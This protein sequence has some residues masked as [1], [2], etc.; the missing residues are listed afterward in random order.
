MTSHRGTKAL[1]SLAFG[2]CSLFAVSAR[3]AGGAGGSGVFSNGGNG[4]DIGQAGSASSAG[5]PAGGSAG[6]A[7]G[8]AG[9]PGDGNGLGNAGG[10]GGADGTIAAPTG[11]AGG[12]GGSLSP[13]FHIGGSIGGGGG[14]AGGNGIYGLTIDFSNPGTVQ[15]GAGGA[16]G[17]GHIGNGNGDGANGGG[18]GD[19]G[20]G[21]VVTGGGITI[22]NSGTIA[23]GNGGAGG[24]GT[25]A[26][27]GLAGAAGV[28][29]SG[30]IGP[31]AGNLTVINSGTI[32]G[33]LAGDGTTQANAI[34]FF[35][36]GNRLELQAGSTIVGNVVATAGGND[37]FAL[38]GTTNASFNVGQIGA[39]QQYQ[40]FASFQK[41][42]DS[43]W[44]LTGTPAQ[45]T[46]SWTIGSGTLAISSDASLGTAGALTFD[47]TIP[48]AGGTGPTLMTT[49][50]FSTSRDI[51][52][53]TSGTFTQDAAGSVFTVNGVVSGNGGLT[54]V[55]PGKL[56][57]TGNNTYI[58]GTSIYGGAT[59][60]AGSDT[61]LGT[62]LVTG[63]NNA[64]LQIM[65][66]VTIKNQF[67]LE[68]P[69]T[70]FSVTSGTGTYAGQITEFGDPATLVKMG[71][72]TLVIT[73]NTN[74]FS[75]GARINEGTLQVTAD[76]ALGLGTITLN[77]GTLQAGANVDVSNLTIDL[78]APV[79]TIDTNGF[80]LTYGG[81]IQDA[82][83]GSVL[84]K[85]GAGTLLLT[86]TQNTFANAIVNQGVLRG[87]AT[88][89]FSPNSAIS[90]V[91]TGTLDVGGFNQKIGSLTGDSTGVVTN[92]G[93]TNATLTTGNATST[94]FAGI[95]QDGAATLAL[96][97]TGTGV[98]TLTGANTYTG[99]TT[100][101]LGT[102]QIGDGGTSG[103]ITGDVTNNGT[104]AFNRSDVVTFAGVVSGSGNLQQVGSGTTIL[105]GANTYAGGTVITAGTLSV[106]T[107]GN[108]GNASGGLTFG[109]GTLRTTAD[110][111]MSRAT[112][113]N[114]GGGTFEVATGTT[115]K[116]NGVIGG[117]GGLIKT[118]AGTL[119]LTGANT[120]TGGT[121]ITQG[122]LQIGDGGTSGS[123]IGNV[124]NNGTLAFNRSDAVTF[125]GVVSGGGNL[126]QIGSGTTILTGANTYTGGTTITQGT[127]QIG[128]GGTSGSITG[129]VT[130]NGTLAFN[131]ADSWTFDGVI[132]G[133]GGVRQIGTGRTNLTGISTYTGA[134]IIDAGTLSVN[135]SIA[136][137]SLT[138]VNSGGT[139]GGNGIVGNTIINAGGT[140]APGNSIGLLTVQGNLTFMSGATYQVEVSATSADRVNVSGI[141]TL[142]GATL[143][144]IYEPSAYV[145][146]R[147]TVLNAA[148][149]VNGTFAG[150]VNTNLPNFVATAAY[151]ANNVYLDLAMQF[152]NGLTVNQTNVANALTNSFNTADGIPL[153]FGALGPSGLTQASGESAT[154]VQQST[155][156]VMDRFLNLMT[157]PY[158]NGRTTAMVP[159]SYAPLPKGTPP[160]MV[161]QQSRWSVWA[162]GYGGTQ[163]TRGIAAIGSNTYSGGIYGFAAG[164][165]YRA[166][167]DTIIGFAL[168]GAGTSY[169]LA[170]GMGSGSSN[171]FQAGLYGRQNFGAAYVTGSLAYGWQ[172][173]TTDRRVM[174][175]Q[176]RARFT[177]NAFSGRLEGGYRFGTPFGGV[178][179]YAA[180]QFTNIAL[181]NYSEQAITGPGLFA[182]NYSSKS[183]TAWR[184]EL[185]L[186][187]DTAFEMGDATL[188]LRGRL[189]WAHNYNPNSSIS[190]SFL[191]L[192]A[193]GFTV[194][195]AALARNAALVSAGAEMK[196]QGG[197]SIAATFEGEFSGRSN[198]YAGK[199]AIRYQ[200]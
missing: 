107:D 94:T 43:T 34:S 108:L 93:P 98:F 9:S 129:N 109:G 174:F 103:S 164:A 6:V 54:Q 132:S 171:V 49:G 186:R 114:A 99:G 145:T 165:D 169:H 63:W 2:I 123:I 173:V 27:V 119:T 146:K 118:D 194:N 162:A 17:A 46:T 50:S 150:A 69:A 161:T 156:N 28:G 62:G 12:N 90:L 149:G 97:K 133:G 79:S 139:L 141:A 126:Q 105:T 135:G 72:G 68:G 47:N 35:G 172:D 112:T 138:T 51:V 45:A 144:A 104:L 189:A 91:T 163:T 71:A 87:G 151:D 100:I 55:G 82:A 53:N 121:T 59:V 29:G 155:F 170:T 124:A 26:P 117:A 76:H 95:L 131:R 25:S 10:G 20:N 64:T 182:L 134:T 198:S 188:T 193:S 89:A 102:L 65:D 42:G 159:M 70:N 24:A 58:G 176:L 157:D 199:G 7:P 191:N 166:T 61:A 83:P 180:G 78:A 85:T 148:G 80:T 11:G 18:G 39:S 196:W 15:G 120:Y 21:I 31:A 19:G 36:N 154:G 41:T 74:N 136:S 30:I 192:P 183:V 44:T 130:N 168:G 81:I 185:G 101:A 3:A 75:A 127:L 48:N 14:G 184:S 153:V 60:V 113:L 142:N 33:G 106:S 160:L 195:G 52:L 22:T 5:I 23:G 187:S 200:W 1:A 111:T 37:V 96:T 56:V 190:A 88:N 84:V 125:A 115:L 197:L 13:S 122:T 57:L 16:G 177:A 116:Q 92:S 67:D 181:P 143:S 32:S 4:G 137:S 147:H 178:T 40:N 128:N 38:G 86:G 175:D 66:G 8:G 140:L 179:P 152:G 167:P 77:G 73:N 110:I 158:A